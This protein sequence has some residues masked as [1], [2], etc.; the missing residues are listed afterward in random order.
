MKEYVCP[1]C[2]YKIH[3]EPP[4]SDDICDICYWEDD[5]SQLRFPRMTG[6]ANKISLI[7]AQKNFNTYGACEKRLIKHTRKPDSKDRLDPKWRIIDLSLDNVEEPGD[8]VD[9]GETYPDDSTRLYYWSENY[10]R[11]IK[12]I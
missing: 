8:G 4:G 12:K 6:G 5:I 1:C 9:Y 11:K 7:D 2:G 3:A 10:W